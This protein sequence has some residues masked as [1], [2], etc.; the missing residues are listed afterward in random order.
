[1][2]NQKGFTIIDLFVVVCIILILA[3]I[4]YPTVSNYLNK[5]TLSATDKL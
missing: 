4:A 3:V 1:M 2:K 5:E